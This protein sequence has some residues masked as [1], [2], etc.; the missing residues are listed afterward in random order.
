LKWK[1]VH[2]AMKFVRKVSGYFDIETL[3]GGTHCYR[4]LRRLSELTKVYCVNSH[5]ISVSLTFLHYNNEPEFS[6]FQWILRTGR[7]TTDCIHLSHV[8]TTGFFLTF[9]VIVRFS[10]RI[11]FCVWFISPPCQY[12]HCTAS[13][14]KM[15]KERWT[16]KDLEASDCGPDE[17]SRHLPRE[18]KV[19]PVFN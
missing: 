17:L 1:F 2:T 5:G 7:K 11:L 10:I 18:S 12:L 4:T 16:G 6:P 9:F 14:D 19:V 15:T 3:G 8:K 13:D